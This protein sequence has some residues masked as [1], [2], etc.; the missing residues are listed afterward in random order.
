MPHDAIVDVLEAHKRQPLPVDPLRATLGERGRWLAAKNPAWRKLGGDLDF[1]DPA[2]VWAEGLRHERLA[3]LKFLLGT[4]PAK[5]RELIASTFAGEPAEDRAAILEVLVEFVRPEDEPFLESALDDRGKEARR[6]AA[7]GLRRLPGSAFCARMVERARGLFRWERGM[8][9]LGRG[10]VVVEP[11]SVCDKG[12]ARDGIEPKPPA[13]AG[14]G[15]RAWWLREVVAAVP[16]S[17]MT[18]ILGVPPEKA[19]AAIKGSDWELELWTGWAASAIRHRDADWA[20][21]LLAARPKGNYPRREY[22]QDHALFA[23]LPPD[24]RDAFLSRLLDADPGPLDNAHPAFGFV[25]VEGATLGLGVGREILRRARGVVERERRDFAGGAREAT[26]HT[27][28]GVIHDHRYH[29][30]QV[31]M[32]FRELASA[33]PLDLVDEAAG[34]VDLGEPPRPYYAESYAAMIDRLRFRRD[35]HWEF[36]P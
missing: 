35:L 20:E 3:A 11:P 33:L 16:P 4:D 36:A 6:Q 5:A 28:A 21:A 27:Y 17:A 26:S 2:S 32:A 9:G 25:R 15:E 31:G 1:D 14:L 19:V 24:R 30:H 13:H 12:M 8:L 23:L 29:E 34:G 7:E 18:E 10:K 22:S